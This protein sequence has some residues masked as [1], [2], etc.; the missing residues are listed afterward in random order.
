M[1]ENISTKKQKGRDKETG[2]CYWKVGN[3]GL[4]SLSPST[5]HGGTHTAVGKSFTGA[6]AFSSSDPGDGVSS[7]LLLTR[8]LT[9][10]PFPRPV[11]C[12]DRL[13]PQEALSARPA[14]SFAVPYP[15]SA[16]ILRE[17]CA[18]TGSGAS[19]RSG[20]VHPRT[21]RPSLSKACVPGSLCL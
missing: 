3:L 16:D 18:H 20:G 13:S 6:G 19:S 9:G 17:T 15:G 8:S 10:S 12:R 1:K 7:V 21:S 14:L 2:R 11:S 4:C 5:P